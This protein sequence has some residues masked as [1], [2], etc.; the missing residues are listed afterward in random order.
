MKEEVNK[1]G[2]PQKKESDRNPGNKKSLKS[3]KK[4]NRRPLQQTVLCASCFNN[5][6]WRGSILVK[7]AWY[8]GCPVSVPEW[9]TLSQDLG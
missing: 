1:Y 2:K 4:Y 7:S 5:T 6:L 8:P 3:N 9:R